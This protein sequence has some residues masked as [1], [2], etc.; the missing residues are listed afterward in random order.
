[1]EIAEWRKLLRGSCVLAGRVEG[2]VMARVHLLVSIFAGY[3]AMTPKLTMSL[4]AG[5]SLA[6]LS[7]AH[8]GTLDSPKWTPSNAP[9]S[10][11]S[12]PPSSALSGDPFG[13]ALPIDKF[14]PKPV[15][16][17]F[18]SPG[19]SDRQDTTDATDTPSFR[20]SNAPTPASPPSGPAVALAP[21]SNRV[22]TR[23]GRRIGARVVD[24][25]GISSEAAIDPRNTY[26]SDPST[27]ITNVMDVYDANR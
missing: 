24:P 15:S 9:W 12:N 10:T 8:A 21:L 26:E 18:D 3:G 19:G 7:P 4:I 23:L 6:A 20:M 22:G 2:R 5:L 13:D 27:R 1:M 14:D 16:S 25:T 11:Q 17:P